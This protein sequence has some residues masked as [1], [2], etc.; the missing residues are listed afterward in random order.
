MDTYAAE[1]NAVAISDS[2]NL[3]TWNRQRTLQE[4]RDFINGKHAT[5]P[6][7]IDIE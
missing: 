2:Q 4:L 5:L 7:D 3:A 6:D 1:N